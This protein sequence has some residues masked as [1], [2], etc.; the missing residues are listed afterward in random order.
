MNQEKIKN[1][2]QDDGTEICQNCGYVFKV[3]LMKKGDD[4]ND[5]GYRYCPFCGDMT[6]LYP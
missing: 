3:E 5:F 2:M 6:D 1:R 4:W